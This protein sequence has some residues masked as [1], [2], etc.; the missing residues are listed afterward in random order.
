MSQASLP[1]SHML[2]TSMFL[3]GVTFATTLPYAAIV[4]IET[5]GLSNGDYATLVSVGAVVGAI[6]SVLIGYVSDRLPDRRILV[7]MSAFMGVLGYGLS[8]SSAIPSSFQSQRR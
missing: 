4:G 3:S 5:L 8:T 6:A 7:L 2:G 1:V